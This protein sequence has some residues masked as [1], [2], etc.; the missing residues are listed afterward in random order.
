[1]LSMSQVAGEA[2]GEAEALD[3]LTKDLH[4]GPSAAKVDNVEVKDIE[5]KS[6][7]SSFTS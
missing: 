5:T 1:M 2:Q 6:G 4:R 3:K 7:E